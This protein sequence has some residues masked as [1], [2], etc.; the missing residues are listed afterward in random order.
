MGLFNLKTK[1][2]L[3]LAPKNQRFNKS[4]RQL[5]WLSVQESIISIKIMSSNKFKCFK[6]AKK[7]KKMITD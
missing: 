1:T 3:V 7:T 4:E 6:S 5:I 2:L